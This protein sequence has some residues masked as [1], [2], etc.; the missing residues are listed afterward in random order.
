MSQ[1][2]TDWL[3]ELET[4]DLQKIF[5]FMPSLSNVNLRFAGQI[6]DSVLE[7]MIQRNIQIK[8][9]CLDAANLVSDACWRLLFQKSGSRL[10]S[11]KL[12]NLDS[13]LNDETVEEMCRSCT[14]LRRLKLKHCWKTSDTSLRAIS[15]L[16]SL[17]HLSLGFIR[18]TDVDTLL[19][20]VK[21][22]GP[23]LRTLSLE[24]FPDADD[25]LLENIHGKC[26]L[27]SKLRLSDNAVFT[28][29]G[30]VQL[31]KNWPNPP[32]KFVDLSSTRDVDYSNPDGPSDPTGLAS[33]GFIA[34]MRHS[35]SMIQKLNISS[36]RHISRAAFE[37]VFSEDK[38]YPY[39]K[40]LDISFHT[41]MDDY[42]VNCIIRCCPAIKKLIAFACFNVREVR[43][44]IGV[45]LIGGLKAQDSIITEGDLSNDV[46]VLM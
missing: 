42:L 18:E 30:F 3:I 38:R 35:G 25:R 31:F 14:A 34:L 44:P 41:V 15:T 22:L 40:E 16:T 26:R 45:A 39:L 11:L 29:K 36:C 13:S 23:N 2:V 37:E 21:R 28:D 43:I 8:H 24:G 17:E 10:E 19:E 27:L 12:S 33:E 1:W 46:A 20:V 32:L 6:K 4:E 7:Y 5:A 9:L